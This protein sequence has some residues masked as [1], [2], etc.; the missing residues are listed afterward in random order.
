MAAFR[1]L[2]PE[3]ATQYDESSRENSSASLES[4]DASLTP[5]SDEEK[6]FEESEEDSSEELPG[7]QCLGL[8]KVSKER[9]RKKGRKAS[10]P[11]EFVNELVEEICESEYYRRRLIF[12]NNKAYKNLEIY[13]KIVA[14]ITKKLLERQQNFNF[15]AQQARTK[16]KACVAVCKKASMT[17]RTKSGIANFMDNRPKWFHKL[18]PYVE[19]R[20]S[21]NPEMAKEP[22][23]Q[24]LDETLSDIQE[25][26]FSPEELPSV[27]TKTIVNGKSRQDLFV[28]IPP[29]RSKKETTHELLKGAV[30]AFKKVASSDP[31]E[32]FIKF[33]KEDNERSRQHDK[34]MAEMH[35]KML[36][37]IMMAPQQMAQ[38]HPYQY[39]SPESYHSAPVRQN[40]SASQ[41]NTGN[42]MSSWAAFINEENTGFH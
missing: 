17:R 14:K 27:S 41:D 7:K 40:S 39:R 9:E 38:Q 3:L 32:S 19:S 33:M 16:F 23:F 5:C 1:K 12:T 26:D 13:Q 2:I 15:S 24:V 22:S 36:Q 25:Q 4:L 21:C 6:D 30:I 29:K 8:S 28:P 37:T 11:D 10:W 31:S 35:L 20:D 34:E 18:F 42:N